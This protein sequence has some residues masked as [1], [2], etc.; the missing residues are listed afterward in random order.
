MTP[1]DPRPQLYLVGSRKAVPPATRDKVTVSLVPGGERFSVNVL[2]KSTDSH[3]R[4][5]QFIQLGESFPEAFARA[6]EIRVD[7]LSK[8][9]STSFRGSAQAL[10]ALRQCIDTKLPDWGVDPKAYDTLRMAPTVIKDSMWFTADDYPYEALAAGQVGDVI[11]RMDVDVTGKVTKCAVV[12]T[13]KSRSLD[14]AT[15]STALR[16]GAFNPAIGGDGRPVA[17]TRIV[18]VI[19]RMES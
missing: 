5:L 2:D 13:S 17:A 18:R 7:G 3:S 12:V 6:W 19:W 10:K 9:V 1:G 8:G 15:C 11:A 4:I 14:D 16:R